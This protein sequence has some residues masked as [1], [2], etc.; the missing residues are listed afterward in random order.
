M[1]RASAAE[2]GLSRWEGDWPDSTAAVLGESPHTLAFGARYV[3]VDA[4]NELGDEPRRR[5]A[6]WVV[7][8]RDAFPQTPVLVCHRQYNYLPGLLPF[9][10]VQLDK[11][12]VAQARRY[13]K[14]YLRVNGVPEHEQRAETLARHVLDGDNPELAQVR[15]LAQTPLFLWMLVERYRRTNSLPASRGSLFDDFSRWYLQERHHE[16]DGGPVVRQYSYEEKLRL[17]GA[18]G[19]E[20][21]H[22]R[23]TELPEEEVAGLVPTGIH[24]APGVLEEII[25]AEMLHREDGKLRFLHQSFQEYFAARHFLEHDARDEGLLRRRV[26]E[27]G[28][29]DT[30]ALLLGFG[31][32]RPDVIRR[33]IE[34]ALKVNPLLTA[35]CLRLSE[36]PDPKLLHQFVASQ[37]RVLLD[38][39]AGEFPWKRA[40]DALAE[41]GRGPARAALWEVATDPAA[42]AGSRATCLER[43]AAMSGLARFE[44]IA[45][46]LREELVSRLASVFNEPAPVVV[47]EAAIA[48]VARAKLTNLSLHLADLVQAK[49]VARAAGSAGGL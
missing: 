4:L 10:V 38:E 26:R 3:I 36:N 39:R 46:K 48:A 27:Y 17:L 28:W 9:P 24:S 33:V 43:L 2:A 31:G 30:L 5:V 34:E 29:H 23:S 44:P 35:R 1:I 22:R 32:D 25:A 15:D 14:D 6:D 19:Y 13:M 12:E 42:P 7:A 41:H 47:R 11:V 45:A 49:D 37:R 18:L 16:K 21:V 8:L 40:A 20:L